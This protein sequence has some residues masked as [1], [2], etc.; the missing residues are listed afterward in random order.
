MLIINMNVVYFRSAFLPVKERSF[1]FFSPAATAVKGV[2][3]DSDI[4][5]AFAVHKIRICIS[6]NA[7]MLIVGRI[8]ASFI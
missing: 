2:A 4:L 8:C 3:K 7:S 1:F 6:I 5:R